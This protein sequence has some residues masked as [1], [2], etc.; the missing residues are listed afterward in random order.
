MANVEK[1]PWLIVTFVPAGGCFRQVHLGLFVL[2]IILGAV[3][4]V[5]ISV[6]SYTLVTI[7]LSKCFWNC[8]H[9]CLTF[10]WADNPLPLFSKRSAKMLLTFCHSDTQQICLQEYMLEILQ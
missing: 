9:N 6:I 4:V 7:T 1:S 10:G 2:S 8:K 3:L 5:A